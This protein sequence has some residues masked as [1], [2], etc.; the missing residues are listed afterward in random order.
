ML[1][2]LVHAV[3]GHLAEAERAWSVVRG[4][5]APLVGAAL[6][7][8][9]L[10]YAGGALVV[11]SAARLVGVA[12]P[13]GRAAL[14]ALGQSAVGAVGGAAG[15][16]A[17][18]YRWLRRDGADAASA[19]LVGAA[20]T[21]VNA[22]TVGLAAALG[23]AVLVPLHRLAPAAIGALVATLVGLAVLLAL[24]L[25]GSGRPKRLERLAA[26]GLRPLGRLRPGLPD[27]VALGARR[28]GETARV[29][30]RGWRPL[31]AADALNVGADAAA[32]ALLF[33]AAGHPVAPEAFLAGYALP[34][35]VTKVSVV[36]GGLGVVEGGMAGLFALLGVP[37]A[38][39]VAVVLVYRALSFWL[40]VAAGLAAAAALERQAP[41][42]SVDG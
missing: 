41:P 1:G 28:A 31:L 30:R 21:L 4:L 22:V 3:L 12:V 13:F 9:A 17:A 32:L 10:S 29:L 27:R 24:A 39:A 34:L 18:T 14:V 40:P 42:T 11:R 6:A 33:W 20:P 16:G 25:W 26:R 8:E 23:I 37:L 38:T 35:L 36:P 19:V 5:R 7:A 2:L 15:S